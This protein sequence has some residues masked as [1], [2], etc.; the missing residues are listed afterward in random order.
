MR[1]LLGTFAAEPPRRPT[2][3]RDELLIK[4]QAMDGTD[5]AVTRALIEERGSWSRGKLDRYERV[6]DR[7]LAYRT[8]EEYL[9]D[10]DRVGPYLTL[11]AGI[12]FEEENL[13]WCERVLAVLEQRVALG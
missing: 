1:D 4:I 7:L 12:S 2:A 5:P 11:M 9:R 3:I 6:R 13:R 10:A 8:E